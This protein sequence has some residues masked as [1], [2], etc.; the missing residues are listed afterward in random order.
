MSSETA[1]RNLKIGLFGVAL[2]LVGDLL[3]KAVHLP[4]GMF[5]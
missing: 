3:I 4:C 1:K 5:M 2:T